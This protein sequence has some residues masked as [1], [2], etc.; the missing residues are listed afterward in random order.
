VTI[1][2]L[3]N[4]FAK[5]YGLDNNIQNYIDLENQIESLIDSGETSELA[6]KLDLL[7]KLAPYNARTFWLRAKYHELIGE[8]EKS[9]SLYDQAEIIDYWCD[10]G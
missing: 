2:N 4:D 1:D 5:L 8:K 7:A 9:K 6:D 3:K 10:L